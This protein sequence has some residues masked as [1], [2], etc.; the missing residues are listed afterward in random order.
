MIVLQELAQ[1]R[2]NLGT[3]LEILAMSTQ[4]HHRFNFSAFRWLAM[5]TSICIF[6]GCG[7]NA[8]PLNLPPRLQPVTGTITIDGKPLSGIVVTF[9]PIAEGGSMTLGETGKDGQYRLSYVGMPGCAPGEYRVML[10]YKTLGDGKSISLDTQSSL[11][12]STEAAK[13]AERMPEKY[14]SQATTLKATVPAG[15]G[16]IDFNL[17]GPLR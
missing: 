16:V 17:T 14:V 5:M 7:S 6:A 12:I 11:I 15:G 1:S 2:I 8:D 10:S 13:A 9:V 4:I 3:F